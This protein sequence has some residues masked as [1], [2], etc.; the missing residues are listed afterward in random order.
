V[1][2]RLQTL[3]LAALTVVTSTGCAV[4]GDD[5]VGESF[6]IAFLLPESETARY[7]AHDRPAFEARI[8]ELCPACQTL[9]YNADQDASRQQSQAEAAITNGADVLV[10]DPVDSVSG[11]VIVR[12]A[13]A[14]GVPVITYDRLVLD[15][16]VLFHVTF[17]N[18]RVGALQAQALLGA[19]D[20][21]GEGELV[22][23]NGSPTDAN[24]AEFRRGA[25]IVLD[26]AA[27]PGI[28]VEVDV[29]GWSP[30]RAQEAMEQALAVLGRDGVAGVYSAN[31]GM[32]AGA[33]AAMRS[34]G[35]DPLP[36]VTGQDAEL[37]AIRRIVTGAQYMTV[38]KPF[39]TQARVAAEVA[40]VA[41]RTGEVAPVVRTTWLDA[42]EQRVPAL[43]L[44]PLVVT[45][46]TIAETVV[47]SGFWTLEEICAG[48]EARCRDAGLVGAGP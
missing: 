4:L 38:Y 21:D 11:G 41:A 22:V 13:S 6:R 17:D 44:E 20:A 34:A 8:A 9:A 33:I 48:I 19:V 47:A 14:Y 30:D 32:A 31:D 23:L 37:E 45:R 46:E 28:G 39:R 2:G 35:L 42:G 16:P 1:R 26:T 12:H 27:A 25:G 24:A 5:A 15:E 29:P 43:V 3:L 36:P 18:E 7:E 10:L 40:L